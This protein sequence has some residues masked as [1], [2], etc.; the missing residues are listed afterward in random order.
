MASPLNLSLPIRL[1]SMFPSTQRSSPVPQ[2]VREITMAL[3]P[4]SPS[5]VFA[6]IDGALTSTLPGIRA[7]APRMRLSLLSMLM[8]RA[9][10][11][12]AGAALQS[13]SA[14]SLT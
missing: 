8:A 5:L 10:R 11:M 12:V 9:R 6:S 1:P 13:S 7:I 2:F 3:D 4:S 14:S